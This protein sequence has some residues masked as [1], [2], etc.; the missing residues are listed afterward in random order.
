MP[1]LINWFLYNK[2]LPAYWV[3]VY[4][5]A[6]FSAGICGSLFNYHA[7]LQTYK[8]GLRVR[9]A[10]TT[11]IY[12]KSLYTILG[13]SQTSGTIVNLMSTD[14]QL[15]LETLPLFM[16]GI[17]API[18]IAVTL[19]LL[20]RYLKAF[21]LISLGVAI[22]AMPLTGLLA[23]KFQALRVKIQVKSDIRLKFVKEFLT[24]IRIVKYYAWE[25]PFVR[26]I[27]Q[28]RNN[29]L[30]SVKA[31][32]YV[33]AFL[34]SLLTNVPA[35]GIG[36][37][38]TFYGIKHSMQFEAV[39][40]SMTYLG[41]LRIPFIFLPMLL[42]FA[43]QYAASFGRITFFALRS[44]LE[45]RYPDEDKDGVGGMRIE[46]G[47]FAWETELSIAE[48]RFIDL[49]KLEGEANKAAELA[50]DAEIKAEH[51]KR[52]ADLTAEKTYI[53]KVVRNL[54]LKQQREQQTAKEGGV[55][56]VAEDEH[57]TDEERSKY[58]ALR[59]PVNNLHDIS[60][61]VEQGKLTTI[62]GSVGSGKSTLGM[63]FLGEVHC[64]AGTTWI[65]GE[66]AYAAQEAWILNATIRDNITF[67]KDYDPV[68]YANVIRACALTTDLAMFPASDLTEIG[69]RGTNLSGGQ[70]QRINVAR[71]MYSKSPIVVLDDPFSAV[72]AHVGEHMFAHVAKA[73]A[74]DGRA[75]LLITNQLHFV[76]E[77]DYCGVL[78]KGKLVEQGP[79][80]ELLNLPGGYLKKMLAKQSAAQTSNV[81]VTDAERAEAEQ[82]RET[83]KATKD[84]QFNPTPEKDEEYRRKGALIKAEER[85][86][87]NIGFGTY[88]D[89]IKAGGIVLLIFVLIAQVLRTAS[90]VMGGVWLSWWSDPTNSHKLSKNSYLGGY[91]GFTIAEAV[92]TVIGSLFFVQFAIRAGRELH[93]G[94]TKA[95][96]RAPT[97]WFDVTP[98]GRVITRF[99]KDID[100]IDIQL[101]Q[102]VEQSINFFFILAGVIASIA[103]GTPFVLIL[104]AVAA[105]AFTALTLHYRKTSIQVQRLEA[106][107]RAPIFSHF[108]E[109]LEGAVTIRAYGMASTF[110]TSNMN[111]IDA[112]TVDFLALRYCSAWFGLTLDMVG[113]IFVGLSFIAMI[114]VRIHSPNTIAVGYMIYAI[115]NTGSI[116]SSL[117]A[118]SNAVTDL[119][120]KMNSAERVLQYFVLPEEA[121]SEIPENTPPAEW[122]A[123]GGIDIKDLVIEYKKG[124]PVLRDLSCHIRPRE[125]VG[126][127]GRTGAGKSTLITALFRTVEP[128][129]GSI[130][131]DNVDITQIGLFDLRSRLSIIPQMPQLFVG[132]VRYNL[133]PF[134]E[135]T[136]EELWKVLKMVKLKSEIATLDGKLEAAVEENGSN[137]SV[138]QR[139]LLSMA[140]CLLRNTHVLLLDEATAAVDVETDALLQSMIRKNFR[141]K[142]VLT[143]AHRL[144]TI[145]DSDRIMVLDAGQILE[146]DTPANLLNKKG[147]VLHGMVEATGPDSAAYLRSIAL[148]Q[149]SVAESIV[150]LTKSGDLQK[151]AELLRSG[152]LF[153]SAELKRSAELA[154][155]DDDTSDSV[156]EIAPSPPKKAKKAPKPK[157]VE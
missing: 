94:M 11:L 73:M 6:V 136:D 67:G 86:S 149:V 78:K 26:N 143:I 65:S 63:A 79:S 17:F 145:M 119:E 123:H 60:L 29:Q 43:G 144:N 151:S 15:L 95:I 50:D 148:G 130:H 13:R 92:F 47:T 9:A 27:N 48:G 110:K 137:F 155:G 109:T 58:P 114:L 12:R 32:L 80:K 44:E 35:L 7:Q 72:D 23:G 55:A 152:D 56:T 121:P 10:V 76:P 140:R 69:E 71:A 129:A 66:I 134:N 97:S 146:F 25:K 126:I 5:A 61:H 20:S 100:F 154:K 38:F 40:S 89:Y 104:F 91:I 138:G 30:T 33:R 87:G 18:Q 14:A 8:F 53:S 84:V 45:P 74:R 153:R 52:A 24:A 77:G 131:I 139:Q 147:G 135:H 34:I 102:L 133:D 62:V 122:P 124:V 64:N 99:S 42:A 127:V 28:T 36:L 57:I 16:Q 118:F 59:D 96:A 111:K 112:N 125:K 83:M 49:E 90:R 68:W 1:Y 150:A 31:T 156:Q 105:I 51:Q 39:F 142:T 3:Y 4:T 41:M 98:I 22:L 2:M 103:V 132:T 70:R 75:V 128:S 21:T 85:E 93:V 19:G 108:T 141:D 120:N 37:T 157:R 101:P 81:S 115:S 107:S 46:N 106:L 88:W 113:N 82:A 117:A 116:S 54:Q